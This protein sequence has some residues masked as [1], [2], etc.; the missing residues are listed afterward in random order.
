MASSEQ[1]VT[2][3]HD[4]IRR[5]AEERDGRPAQVRGTGK[6]EP[7]ILRFDLPGGA[8]AQTLEHIS[9]EDWFEKFEAQQLAVVLQ[10]HKA[11]GEPSTFSR[12]I[13]R[14]KVIAG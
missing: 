8:D 7:G 14:D 13:A 2:I 5:W 3:D 12:I 6:G 1:K 9:W 4:E 10:E 11:D